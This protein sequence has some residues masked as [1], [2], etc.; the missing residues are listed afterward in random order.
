[1]NDKQ[2]IFVSII[3]PIYNT[4]LHFFKE[5]LD[6][7]TSQTLKKTEFLL[8][9][10]GENNELFSFSKQY[11]EKD[12]RFILSIQP[13]KGVSATRNYGLKQAQGE[14]ITF[15]DAD[16]SIDPECCR[17][18]Y[19]Y[20]K[21]N[22]SDVVLFDYIPTASQFEKTTYANHSITRL[23]NTSVEEI[24]KQTIQLTNEKFVAAVSTWC[25]LIRKEL[26][27]SY[28]IQFPE[29]VQIAVD[30]SFSFASYFFAKN[31]SY[32]NKAF[33]K[34][35]KVESSITWTYY[36]NRLP[37][38]LAHLYAIKKISSKYSVLIGKQAVE[39][40]FG[41][42]PLYLTENN[43]EPFRKRISNICQ[44]VKSND[45]QFLIQNADTSTFPIIIKFELFL[46][47]HK[48]T[49]QIWLHALKWKILS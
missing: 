19:E 13:H 1:M 48:F 35:N 28:F 42:W 3:V 46:M 4:P 31:I 6:S 23:S 5:C 29:Y 9:F 24:Q 47:R 40:F 45:F 37:L 32:I 10:D 17:E 38:I 21:K 49:I 12:S 41:S 39:I 43:P 18:T 2:Q 8:I 7:L 16:D 22:K 33:Y 36:S 15:V 26:I 44:V 30:R 25:K 27:D 20:A 14:Y 11:Q 34:Y